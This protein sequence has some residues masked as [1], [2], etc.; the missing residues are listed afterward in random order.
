LE[1]RLLLSVTDKKF[2]HYFIEKLNGREP[3]FFEK[4]YL[5][6]AA[7]CN[8]DAEKSISKV[9]LAFKN[10]CN[11]AEHSKYI[12]S[13]DYKYS[14]GM[15]F[16]NFF[17]YVI[18]KQEAVQDHHLLPLNNKGFSNLVSKGYLDSII[19]KDRGLIYSNG[20]GI[21]LFLNGACL[22]DEQH[23]SALWQNQVIKSDNYKTDSTTSKT[24]Y[25]DYH[26]FMCL[27]YDKSY[28]E[29]I[30]FLSLAFKNWKEQYDKLSPEI[31]EKL[32]A[33]LKK[34][35]VDNFK[36]AQNQEPQ[37]EPQKINSNDS[38]MT[39][40]GLETESIQNFVAYCKTNNI[41]HVSFDFDNTLSVKHSFSKYKQDNA[42]VDEN[43][44]D[45]ILPKTNRIFWKTLFDKLKKNGIKPII[46]SFQ[47]ES[48][49][50]QIL[51]LD[52]SFRIYGNKYFT[53][54]C[55]ES[56]KFK[57]INKTACLQK[58][59]KDINLIPFKDDAQIDVDI[60]NKKFE[61][62]IELCKKFD[63][64]VLS[65]DFDNTMTQIHTAKSISEGGLELSYHSVEKNY[66]NKNNSSK[67]Y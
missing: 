61:D 47:H 12:D 57:P 26:A 9:L 56:F 27:Y 13:F 23:T 65:F 63:V 38:N 11:N 46:T 2:H 20:V 31:K 49:I 28:Q 66:G 43:D 10:N 50:R 35:V 45:E 18:H 19:P 32:Q 8:I 58:E 64:S 59:Y 41:T 5:F 36:I 42:I 40:Y 55:G 60:L 29:Y 52:D 54:N 21:N 16:Y 34:K 25:S 48:T 44:K 4:F 15:M 7:G 17:S 3:K 62:L 30:K 37:I 1:A 22:F 51:E 24:F 39:D 53:T 14:F 33:G 67:V 6:N